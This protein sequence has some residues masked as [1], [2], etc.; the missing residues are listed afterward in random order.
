MSQPK[1]SL[2]KYAVWHGVDAPPQELRLRRRFRP[3]LR[4]CGSWTTDRV[5]QEGEPILCNLAPRAN[6][7]WGDSCNT[8]F[9]GERA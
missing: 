9:V 1:P 5:G 6:G 3:A 7:Y 4:Q 2:A 8:I